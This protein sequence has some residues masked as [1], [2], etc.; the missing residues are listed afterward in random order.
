MSSGDVQMTK[1]VVDD[2]VEIADELADLLRTIHN[3]SMGSSKGDTEKLDTQSGHD[4]VEE[5][6][7]GWGNL[8]RY[9]S[10]TKKRSQRRFSTQLATSGNAR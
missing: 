3:R 1:K 4:R 7:R 10:I 2:L 6:L 9:A 5:V 8:R